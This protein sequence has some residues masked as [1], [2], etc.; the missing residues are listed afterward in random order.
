M[1][2]FIL[3]GILLVIVIVALFDEYETEIKHNEL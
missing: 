1:M 3:L 2:E